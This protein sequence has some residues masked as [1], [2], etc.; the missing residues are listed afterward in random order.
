MAL[1]KLK[2]TPSLSAESKDIRNERRVPYDVI[3]K[4]CELY[5]SK[6]KKRKKFVGSIEENR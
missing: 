1:W 6:R 3:L 5:N 4:G 2:H